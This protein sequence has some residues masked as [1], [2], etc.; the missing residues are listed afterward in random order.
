MLKKILVAIALLLLLV[1]GGGIAFVATK[2]AAQRPASTETVAATPERVERGRYLAATMSCVHCH[3]TPNKDAFG[4]PPRADAAL[5]AG[6]ECWENNTG[7]P[8]VL[9]APNLTPDKETGLGAWTDGEIAR[10]IR[11]GVDRAGEALFPIMPYPEYRSLADED[12]DALVAYLRSLPAVK[13]ATPERELKMPLNIFVNFVPQPLTGPVPP[14]DRRDGIAYGRYLATVTGCRMCHT[15]VDDKHR[16]VI[17]REFAG[18]QEFSMPGL[19]KVASAN[20]T[21]H[22]TGLGDRSRE[23]F[24]GLFRAFSDPALAAVKVAPSDN[25]VMPWM[26]LAAMSDED[27]GAIHAF[28]KTLPPIESHIVKRPRPAGLEPQPQPTAGHAEVAPGAP[29]A[30]TP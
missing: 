7:F 28:L 13:R 23:A 22:A 14:P 30:A 4:F 19:H 25:T 11:E 12:V 21:P 15:P 20:L 2:K 26:A 8:G 16:P 3:S 17:G 5:G 18:G 27:L 24:I 10:A 1:I 29:Q 9:C 6:G